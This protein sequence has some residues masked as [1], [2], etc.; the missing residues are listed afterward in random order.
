MVA[1]NGARRDRSDHSSLPVTTEQIV[2]TAAA[3]FAAGANALHLHVRDGQGGHSLDAGHYNETLAELAGAVPALRVQI[4]TEAAGVFD[5]ASQLACLRGVNP[6]WASISVREIARDPAL[7]PKVYGVCA[8]QGTKVQHILYDVDDVALL[9]AWQTEGIVQEGQSSVLFVLGRYSEGQVSD[10]ADLRPFR[11]AMPDTNDW[12]ICA[13]G[14]QEHACLLA[15]AHDGGSLRV[16]F[17][18]S[19][20]DSNGNTYLDNAASVAALRATLERHP[21]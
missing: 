3:C 20:T 16:G 10:P 5:V 18:N 6:E 4:T 1:P 14:P 11:D 2:E 15:A 13:F 21:S 8:D 12:M 19:L 9:K 7:A 17:E